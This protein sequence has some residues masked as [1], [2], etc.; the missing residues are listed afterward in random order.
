M[1]DTPPDAQASLQLINA[2]INRARS[3]FSENGHLYLVW[4]WVVLFCSL[5]HFLLQHVL[6]Y[7]Q[8]YMVWM[9]C[10][11][12][13]IYQ[14][15]YLARRKKSSSV[16]TYTEEILQYVWLVFVIVTALLVA[17]FLHNTSNPEANTPVFLVMYGMPTLLSGIILQHRSL[18]VG[19]Y[20]C[21]IL[22]L[23]TL[24][25]PHIFYMPLLSAAVIAAWIIP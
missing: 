14:V 17:I 2:M 1:T 24:F 15:V 21:W 8:F 13:A 11:V 22:A 10:W 18:V 9:L 3:R 16:R 7:P 4:G 5:G 19:A 25:L 6:S 20:C 12:A 23:A